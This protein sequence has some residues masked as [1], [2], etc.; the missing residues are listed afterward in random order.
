MVPTLGSCEEQIEER[1]KDEEALA[2][3]T[4]KADQIQ[5]LPY[6][7]NMTSLCHKTFNVLRPVYLGNRCYFQM[8]CHEIKHGTVQL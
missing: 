1:S 4:W 2:F 3:K 7:I 5:T 6:E 8:Y